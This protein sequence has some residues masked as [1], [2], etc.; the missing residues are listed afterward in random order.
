M[1]QRIKLL[2]EWLSQPSQSAAAGGEGSPS[3]ESKEIDDPL[4]GNYGGEEEER[5]VVQCAAKIHQCCQSLCDSNK[6]ALE[7]TASAEKLDAEKMRS[8]IL[9]D[10]SNSDLDWLLPPMLQGKK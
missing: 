5:A 10:F 1:S 2:G 7:T 3:K 9:R 6:S 4:Y 8:V